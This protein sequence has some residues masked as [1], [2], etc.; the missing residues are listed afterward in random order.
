MK[1]FLFVLGSNWQLS[2]AE[3]DNVLK[4]SQF[5]G[6]II[7]YSANVAIVEFDS[8]HNEHYYVN[9]LM[10]L[11]YILGGTQKIAEIYDF[12]NIQTINEAFPWRVDNFNKVASVR[13]KITEVLSQDLP[14]IFKRIK[15]AHIFFA[16]SIYPNL[17]DEEYYSQILLKHFL[18]FLNKEISEILR[19]KYAKKVSYY[20]YPEEYIESGNLNPIFPHHLI[21]YG[22]LNEDRAEIIFGFTEEGVYIAR[23]FTT[24]DPNFKKKID[25]DRPFK[26]FKSSIS[27]KLA[28][29]MLNFLNL[30][31]KR[32]KQAILDPFVG[33]AT[34]LMFAIVE[35]FQVYGSDIE[36][37]KVSNSIRNI[38]WLYNELEEKIPLSM[39]NHLKV[40]SIE[41][42]SS[43]F[44]NNFFD[45]VATE[46]ELGPFYTKQPYYSEV[47]ELFEKVLKPLYEYTFKESY[48]LLKPKKRLSL[49]API[50]S[51]VDGGDVQM[52]IEL[53]AKSYG[54][55][56]IPLIDS[57]RIINKSN[58]KL[59]LK[60]EQVRALIDAKKDQ[61]IKR[62]FY[63]FEK[64]D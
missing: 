60:K 34:I 25:E 51:T 52:N 33:N 26:E 5:K 40:S 6:R 49:I 11:Q 44:M 61:I 31:E 48:K 46:P 50:I 41:T 3:L 29:I 2:L 37:E 54:F 45:G 27:P 21:T 36:E 39:N 23:T 56:L 32:E 59:Q 13:E 16:V 55:H 7:D 14:L 20:K 4:Y 19:K 57:E 10:E 8:L 17:F 62:K 24:D 47:N 63:V 58:I 64:S 28:I 18:P 12:I 42:L 38:N 30:F 22:L 43:Q 1:R 53:I 9:N 35:D 15:N